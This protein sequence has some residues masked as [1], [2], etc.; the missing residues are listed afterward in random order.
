MVWW[1]GAGPRTAGRVEVA[2]D[3]V[4]LASTSAEGRTERIAFADVVRVRLDRG[5]LHVARRDGWAVRIGS[6]DA[7]GALRELAELLADAA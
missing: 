6:L 2:E 4:A 5:E 1:V 3:S 7:P